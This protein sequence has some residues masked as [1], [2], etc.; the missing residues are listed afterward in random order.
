MED[1]KQMDMINDILAKEDIDKEPL[2]N[3]EKAIQ[4]KE[5]MNAYSE[6]SEMEDEAEL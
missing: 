3:N 6:M 1:L 4:E 2:E 5:E